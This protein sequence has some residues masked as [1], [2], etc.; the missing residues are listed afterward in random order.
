MIYIVMVEISNDWNKEVSVWGVS[1]DFTTA[2][3]YLN[4]ANEEYEA[5][6]TSHDVTV[7]IDKWEGD[8]FIATFDGVK[9]E[10][11]F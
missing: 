6:R 8:K 3:Q 10:K 9:W 2:L 4:D 5:Y 11:P 7:Y 1:A